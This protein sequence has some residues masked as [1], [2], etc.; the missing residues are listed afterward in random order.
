[1]DEKP[2]R[3]LTDVEE[4]LRFLFEI[5]AGYVAQRSFSPSIEERILG[6]RRCPLG[7]ARTKAVPGEG[8][9]DADLMFIGEA[10]GRDED[11]QG[12][13]FVGRAGQLLTKIIQAMNYRREDVYITNIVKCRPPN[14]REP[15]QEETNACKGYL[16]EQIASIQPK[17]IVTLGNVPTHFFIPSQSGVTSLRG[18]FY[19]FEDIL[20]MPTFHPS[21]LV[22]NESNRLLKKMVWEDMKKV[23]AYL[24]KT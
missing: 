17:V 8:S 24:G 5:G 7:S 3:L 2:D 9:A 4:N 10:P 19:P 14:N 11:L 12:R 6:C 22:R 23:M 13:P 21:Y 1:L 20:V 15:N 16:F 18:T